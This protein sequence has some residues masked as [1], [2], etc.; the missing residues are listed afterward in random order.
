MNDQLLDLK[1]NRIFSYR[2]GRYLSTIMLVFASLAIFIGCVLFVKNIGYNYF[3]RLGGLILI[4]LGVIAFI[5]LELFQVNFQTNEYRYCIKFFNHEKG[6]WKSLSKVQYLSIVKQR[7]TIVMSRPS[8][9]GAEVGHNVEECVLRFF[10]K[11]GYYIEI[12]D[13]NVKKEAIE[14]G[15]IIAK[16]LDIKLLDATIR[17]PEFIH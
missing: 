7:K 5:P 4:G 15:Q 3:S 16:G 13:F 11:A 17:P 9:L 2:Y 1:E 14:F 12:D 8:L 10:I 6:E